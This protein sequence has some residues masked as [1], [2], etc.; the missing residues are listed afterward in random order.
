MPRKARNI[1]SWIGNR[2]RELRT[3]WGD[4]GISQE[5]LAEAIGTTVLVSGRAARPYK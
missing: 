3:G 1:Y 4:T 5:E 2:I